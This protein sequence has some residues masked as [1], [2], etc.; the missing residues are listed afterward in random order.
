ML[1]AEAAA[2]LEVYLGSGRLV[3]WSLG[4]WLGSKE[5]IKVLGGIRK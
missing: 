1:Q 3:F 4:H 2:Q 5:G